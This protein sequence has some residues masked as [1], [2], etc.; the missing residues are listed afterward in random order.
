MAVYVAAF[1]A[2]F[3][4]VYVAAFAASDVLLTISCEPVPRRLN[5]ERPELIPTRSLSEGH[6]Q[7]RRLRLGLVWNASFLTASG[8]SAVIHSRWIIF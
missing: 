8:I 7:F 1:M 4:A 6:K 3:V 2:A 5:S